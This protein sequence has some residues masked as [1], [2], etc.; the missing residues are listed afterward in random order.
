MSLR[1]NR[2]PAAEHFYR[3]A[4]RAGSGRASLFNK[5]GNLLAQRG[6]SSEAEEYYR[7]ALTLTPD[8]A[9]AHFNLGSACGRAGRT[10]EALDHLR[11]AVSLNPSFKEAWETLALSL[12]EEARLPEALACWERIE[13]P[14]LWVEGDRTD[15]ARWWGSHYSKEEFHARLK[16]VRNVQTHRLSPA[17][18]MLHHDQPEALAQRLLD[19]LG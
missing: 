16:V 17:G 5:L 2:K 9:D 1:E 19:F 8:F 14:L 7:R 10:Q 4:L 11:Q 13:A 3:S 18:H 12:E 6:L 15:L